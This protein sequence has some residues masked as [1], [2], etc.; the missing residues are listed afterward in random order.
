ME[1]LFGKQTEM[2]DKFTFEEIAELYP[3][4]VKDGNE[5][6]LSDLVQYLVAEISDLKDQMN[7][8]DCQILYLMKKL[9]NES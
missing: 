9:D 6:V 3:E 2:A 5:I 4:A 7:E 1:Y 8:K